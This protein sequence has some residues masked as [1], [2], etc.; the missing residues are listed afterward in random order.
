MIS[1]FYGED[2]YRAHGAIA[3]IAEKQTARIYWLT[4][5]DLEARPLAEIL[6]QGSS[7]FGQYLFVIQDA[8]AFPLPLQEAVIAAS[9]GTAAGIVWDRGAPDKRSR[10]FRHFKKNARE[11]VY[12]SPPVMVEWLAREVSQRGG[13]LEEAAGMVLLTRVGYDG[14]RLLNTVDQLL[15]THDRLTTRVVSD[16]LPVKGEAEIFAALQAVAQ[17]NEHHALHHI[18]GLLQ[19]GS[20]E[21]YIISMLAYQLRTLV[22][23]RRGLARQLTAPAIAQEQG[24]HPYV[25]QKNMALARQFSP[26]VLLDNL[27]KILATDFAIKQGKVDPR[28]GLYMLVIALLQ[29]ARV[30]AA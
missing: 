9:Q 20:S 24:L 17:G 8:A 2:T 28:T 21:F 5:G 1:Y 26:T 11:F 27:T 22:L 15:L 12:P 18:E 6:S 14:W 25:V 16:A 23:I 3:A 10:L 30:A 4:R 29:P 13:V 19:A 7:L